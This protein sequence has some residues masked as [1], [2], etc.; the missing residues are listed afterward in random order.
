MTHRLSPADSQRLEILASILWRCFV[1]TVIAMLFTFVVSWIGRDP[2][3]RIYSSLCG[4]SGHETDLFVFGFLTFIK[5][6]NLVFFL[7][8]WVALRWYL[9]GAKVSGDATA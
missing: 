2:I 4:L 5:C 7:I 6:L 8:P 3:R 9:R 1:A